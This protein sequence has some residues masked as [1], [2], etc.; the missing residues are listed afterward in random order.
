MAVTGGGGVNFRR[1]Y[2]NPA[3]QSQPDPC[4]AASYNSAAGSRGDQTGCTSALRR[5]TPARRQCHSLDDWNDVEHH[6]TMMY[7]NI[8]SLYYYVI[9]NSGLLWSSAAVAEVSPASL[10]TWRLL[11]GCCL[12]RAL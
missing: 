4:E 2:T 9:L 11:L 6:P 5:S 12:Y 8:P 7:Y 1:P 3:N 10:T